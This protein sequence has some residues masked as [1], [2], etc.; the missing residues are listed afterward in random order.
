MSG[1]KSDPHRSDRVH[2]IRK[3]VNHPA[4][5][6]T[7]ASAMFVSSLHEVISSA[8][9]FQLGAHHGILAYAMLQAARALPDLFESAER[10][11]DAI[12]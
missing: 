10:A 8:A 2:R 9:T 7:T 1:S 12:L 4:M 5:L 3:V 6:L 11:E